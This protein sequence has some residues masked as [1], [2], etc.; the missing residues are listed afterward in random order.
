MQE[1][2][3]DRV[4]F[5]NDNGRFDELQEYQDG[6]TFLVN[7]AVVQNT[8]EN[9]LWRTPNT[10]SHTFV[11]RGAPR[12][13]PLTTVKVVRADIENN[14]KPTNMT[15]HNLTA[16]INIYSEEDAGVSFI[17]GKVQ[18]EMGN[19]SLVIVGGNGFLF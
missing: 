10:S 16:H 2:Y 1:A 3:G 6:D 13:S 14:G 15:Y 4:E 19:N 8:D 9:L 5:Q 18:K 7:G 11:S 12:R 17:N